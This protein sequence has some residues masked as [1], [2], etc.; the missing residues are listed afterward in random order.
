MEDTITLSMKHH[1]IS[2]VVIK[3]F[4]FKFY[5]DITILIPFIVER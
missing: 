4:K 1:Y 2:K 5:K 3:D